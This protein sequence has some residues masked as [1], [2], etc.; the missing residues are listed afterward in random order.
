VM[1][2]PTKHHYVID[3]VTVFSP[4]TEVIEDEVGACE[5]I[6]FSY[7]NREERGAS[8]GSGDFSPLP[9]GA[10]PS[11]LCWESTVLSIRNG[12]AHMPTGTTSGVLGSVNT[13][14]VNVTAGFQNGWANLSFRGAGATTTGLVSEV[15]SATI[16]LATGLSTPGAQTY[17]GLPVVGMMV[18]TFNNG[19]LTCGAAACQ[20]NYGS[21][22]EHKY[23]QNI[24]P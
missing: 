8:A 3:D 18:R 11:A 21:A 20:G 10:T 17:F 19:T 15:G 24:T 22:F 14:N 6:N 16:A 12:A 4:F 5:T 9:P 1:T 7:F 2:F 23:L 13:A